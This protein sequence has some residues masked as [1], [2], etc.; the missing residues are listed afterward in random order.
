MYFIW[1]QYSFSIPSYWLGT[2]L[3]PPYDL[4]F[5][6]GSEECSWLKIRVLSDGER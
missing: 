5:T 1:I 2:L 4:L 3:N 6:S